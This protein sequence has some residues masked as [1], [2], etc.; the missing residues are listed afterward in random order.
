MTVKETLATI[1][2]NWDRCTEDT[3][4]RLAK[5]LIDLR[6]IPSGE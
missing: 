3:H 4:S 2:E 5:L 6:K 1:D